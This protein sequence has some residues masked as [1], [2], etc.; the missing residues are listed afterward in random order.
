MWGQFWQSSTVLHRAN[1]QRLI[2]A[3]SHPSEEAE[4]TKPGTFLLKL[5]SA[6]E[7]IFAMLCFTKTLSWFVWFLA[8]DEES[9]VMAKMSCSWHQ[10]HLWYGSKHYQFL[11]RTETRHELSWE[12]Q[13]YLWSLWLANSADL[14]LWLGQQPQFSTQWIFKI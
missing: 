11:L 10:S 5:K 2:Q 12:K 1:R 7:S 8:L 9:S 14:Q 3:E 6:C 4:D 13:R